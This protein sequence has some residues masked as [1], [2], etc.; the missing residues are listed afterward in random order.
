MDYIEI[1]FLFAG[2]SIITIF[3][4]YYSYISNQSNKY[5]IPYI[6]SSTNNDINQIK[7]TMSKLD[8]SLDEESTQVEQSITTNPSVLQI[9]YDFVKKNIIYYG[10]PILHNSIDPFL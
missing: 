2:I 5:I 6:S 8:E 7:L 3:I 10:K 1:L 4:V 9:P